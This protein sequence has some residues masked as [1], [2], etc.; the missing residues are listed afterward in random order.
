MFLREYEYKCTR[1]D[2]LF[3]EDVGNDAEMVEQHISNIVMPDEFE[4]RALEQQEDYL[5]DL[6]LGSTHHCKDG[7]LGIGELI[8]CSPRYEDE[9]E[10]DGVG[11][12]VIEA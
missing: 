7:G 6:Q 12:H 8:G 1:C 4:E 3:G 10:L 9:S 5:G 11:K 2:A